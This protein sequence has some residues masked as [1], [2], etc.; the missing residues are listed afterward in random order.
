MEGPTHPWFRGRTTEGQ[1]HAG[2]VALRAFLMVEIYINSFVLTYWLVQY[3]TSIAFTNKS[4]QITSETSQLELK[5]CWITESFM[6]VV[7]SAIIV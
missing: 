4:F 3:D 5:N 2:D 7:R 6:H 1:N